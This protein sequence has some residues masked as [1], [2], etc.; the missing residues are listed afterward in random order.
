MIN[1]L[2]RMRYID[3]LNEMEIESISSENG[4]GI[5]KSRGCWL[6][7]TDLELLTKLVSQLNQ[8]I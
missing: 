1:Y 8:V 5:A 3:Y 6:Y 2:I 7:K 4:I